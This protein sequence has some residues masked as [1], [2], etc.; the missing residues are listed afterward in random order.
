MKTILHRR[1]GGGGGRGAIYISILMRE[2]AI[3]ELT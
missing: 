2:D 1:G 3:V